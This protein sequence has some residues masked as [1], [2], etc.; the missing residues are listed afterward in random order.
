MSKVMFYNLLQCFLKMCLYIHTHYECSKKN[1]LGIH[2]YCIFQEQWFEH[3]M[4][5]IKNINDQLNINKNTNIISQTHSL[6]HSLYLSISLSLSLSLYFSWF[7]QCTE[8]C[9]VPVVENPIQKVL[10]QSERGFQIS[11]PVLPLMV[12]QQGGT[13]AGRHQKSEI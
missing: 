5:C 6:S 4:C 3:A 7:L 1:G 12:V 8:K 11:A 13:Q 10:Q 9:T 2:S